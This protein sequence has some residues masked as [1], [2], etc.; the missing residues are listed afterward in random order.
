M[1]ETY[2]LKGE[3][4]QMQWLH[5]IQNKKLI[6]ISLTKHW[7]SAK[8]KGL[9]S[10]CSPWPP[11]KGSFRE[12]LT[13]E[14]SDHLTPE[15]PQACWDLWAKHIL[16]I[17][18]EIIQLN[19]HIEIRNSGRNWRLLFSSIWNQA[20]YSHSHWRGTKKPEDVLH[21]LATSSEALWLTA[22]PR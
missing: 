22:S 18:W 15:A 16:P 17:S 10:Y 4:T 14:W 11:T 19:E 20:L 1:G 3:W 5:W 12:A 7:S 9:C 21:L 13:L 8:Q 2:A 6:S